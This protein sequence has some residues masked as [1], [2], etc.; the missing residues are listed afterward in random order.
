VQDRLGIQSGLEETGHRSDG[1]AEGYS[2]TYSATFSRVNRG[3]P[4]RI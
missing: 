3:L 1:R 4:S 2:L